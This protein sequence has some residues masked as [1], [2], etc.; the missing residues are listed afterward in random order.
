MKVLRRIGIGDVQHVRNTLLSVAAFDAERIMEVA[1]AAFLVGSRLNM[2]TRLHVNIH[3][4]SRGERTELLT[5]YYRNQHHQLEQWDCDDVALGGILLQCDLIIQ[6]DSTC[7][8]LIETGDE[9]QL[10]K[11]IP[12]AS[13]EVA[14][15]RHGGRF[16]NGNHA[17]LTT[18]QLVEDETFGQLVARLDPASVRSNRETH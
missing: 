16:L 6:G 9:T 18:S 5:M 17:R 4:L 2:M 14:W 7:P 3:A 8:R 13:L 12:A 1:A 11:T 15:L 10:S